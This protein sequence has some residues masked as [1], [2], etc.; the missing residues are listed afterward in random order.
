MHHELPA[1][2]DLEW[3][4]KRAKNLVREYRAGDADARQRVLEAVGEPEP[5]RLSDAQHVL[6]VEHGFRTWAE[7]KRWVETREPEPPVGRIGRSP[8]SAYEE[9]AR[10]LVAAFRRSDDA[11]RRRVGAHLPRGASGELPLRDAK[12]VVAREYGF[13]TWRDLVHYQ[14]QAI[15]TFEE[16]PTEG[17]LARAWDAMKASDVEG[18][19]ALLDDHPGL[20]HA[21]YA[22]AATTLL[23]AL[24]QPEQRHV[25]LRVAELLIERGSALDMPLNLAACFNYVELVQL[26]LAAGARH[27]ADDIWGVTALQTAIYHGAREAADVLAPRGLVPD[28]LYVSAATGRELEKWF[29]ERGGL[30]RE[31]L[32]VRP[33]LADV[34]WPP[35]PPARDDVDEALGEA[36][37]LAAY[38]G[39][40]ESMA[41]LLD[42]GASPDGKVNGL[43]GL[44]LAVILDRVDTLRWLVEHGADLTVREDLYG[45]TPLGWTEH[46]RKGS[47]AHAYLLGVTDE[48]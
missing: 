28:A 26:L 18:L 46:N 48:R 42:R 3:Y 41:F 2:L 30:R 5:F 11:A 19:R 31:A 38:S 12:I 21:K 6:A 32:R 22:G 8:I 27:R 35:Q 36:M 43:T 39:R 16:R 47:A 34:G 14:Q 20:V 45:S 29:D 4:R 40:I 25:D 15:D 33:N 17:D 37:A 24:T 23:E 13:P 44:H 7:F 1:H 10:V 9:R